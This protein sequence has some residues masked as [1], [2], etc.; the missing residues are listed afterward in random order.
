MN[1]SSFEKGLYFTNKQVTASI[2]LES[3]FSKEIRIIFKKGH[4]MKKHQTPFPIVVHILEGTILFGL[5]DEV[6]ILKK[7]AIT[8]LEGSIPHN[9]LA[10]E[11]SIVRLTLSKHDKVA[12]VEKVLQK[13]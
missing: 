7:G 2:L 4:E 11:D 1:Q 8:S 6:H 13:N 12:R 5:E 10:K 3:S 9:L